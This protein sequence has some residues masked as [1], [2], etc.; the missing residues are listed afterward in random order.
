MNNTNSQLIHAVVE[1]VIGTCITVW[2]NRKISTV[3]QK[4]VFLEDKIK[5][6]E[7]TL[8]QHHELIKKLFSIIETISPEMVKITKPPSSSFKNS[9]SPIKL[10]FNNNGGPSSVPSAGSTQLRKDDKDNSADELDAILSSEIKD[11]QI[12]RTATLT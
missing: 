1:L 6:Y 2:L 9:D 8:V 3:T 10:D 11:I 5:Y 12:D 7:N 4:V